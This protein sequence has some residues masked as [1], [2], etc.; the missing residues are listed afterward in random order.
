MSGSS[1]SYVQVTASS[2]TLSQMPMCKITDWLRHWV[3]WYHRVHRFEGSSPLANRLADLLLL[4]DLF[5]EVAHSTFSR[6]LVETHKMLIG[7]VE[8]YQ[9]QSRQILVT[10]RYALDTMRVI[11]RSRELYEPLDD[12]RT[13]SR[14]Q[15][16][17]PCQEFE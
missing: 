16:L 7:E 15:V 10:L 5:H 12:D 2:R 13:D 1:E 6:E 11:Q 4:W 17:R 9:R 14:D 3:T 8:E